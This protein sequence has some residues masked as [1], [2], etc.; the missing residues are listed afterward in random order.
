MYQ[1]RLPNTAPKPLPM[2]INCKLSYSPAYAYGACQCRRWAIASCPSREKAE[3]IY[4]ERH[5]GIEVTE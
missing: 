3:R 2:G 5:L 1:N 4:T